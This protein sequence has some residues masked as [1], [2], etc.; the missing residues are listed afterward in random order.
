MSRSALQVQL[1]DHHLR[2]GNPTGGKSKAIWS[3]RSLV[4]KSN[5][6]QGQLSQL[7]WREL[8]VRLRSRLRSLLRNKETDGKR[9]REIKDIAL[10]AGI[11]QT[12]AYPGQEQVGMN[13]HAPAHLLR[14]VS[15]R[16]LRSAPQPVDITPV[17]SDNESIPLEVKQ[18]KST[19]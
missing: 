1:A 8:D 2:K 11:A 10:A 12:K 4:A 13:L 3:V 15:E 18:E 7:A 5:E 14:A 9:S 16:I 17:A 19:S 6:E